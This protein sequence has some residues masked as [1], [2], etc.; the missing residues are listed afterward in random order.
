MFGAEAL[1]TLVR[2]VNLTSESY[3]LYK[4]QML[5]EVT[6]VEIGERDGSPSKIGVGPPPKSAQKQVVIPSSTQ[7]EEKKVNLS[8]SS[9][10]LASCQVSSL[11]SR[12]ISSSVGMRMLSPGP[13]LT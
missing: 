9:V 4:D 13:N 10:S 11:V 6:R 1:K 2:I 3:E 5:S 12:H 7:F 8:I